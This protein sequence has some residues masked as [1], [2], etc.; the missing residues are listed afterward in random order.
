M[1]QRLF[2]LVPGAQADQ[3]RGTYTPPGFA[4]EAFVH[5]SFAHQ[6]QGTLDLHFAGVERVLLIELAPARLGD[7]LRLEPS[8]GGEDFPHLYR[9]LE[10]ADAIG[11]WRLD[12]EPGMGLRVPDLERAAT[13]EVDALWPAD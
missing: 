6:L 3:L 2:H 13:L 10:R 1:T 7:D 9:P 11:A 8:R 5:L 12:A 4:T